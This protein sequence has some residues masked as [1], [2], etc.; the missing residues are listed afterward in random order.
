MP[1]PSF[2]YP[3]TSVHDFISYVDTFATSYPGPGKCITH[4]D[5]CSSVC[6][7]DTTVLPL[8]GSESLGLELC[9]VVGQILCK[10][11]ASGTET[12]QAGKK[13]TY[14]GWV[15]IL[16]RLTAPLLRT[17]VGQCSHFATKILFALFK[18]WA[19]IGV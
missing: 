16:E 18:G 5:A 12:L 9:D 2:Y 15:S 7:V 6:S 19:C 10:A 4:L 8:L 11:L 13:N 14:V 1:R 3:T 17:D